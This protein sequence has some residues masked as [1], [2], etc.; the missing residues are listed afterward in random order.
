MGIT[1]LN[2]GFWKSKSFLLKRYKAYQ[3]PTARQSSPN[4]SLGIERGKIEK[5]WCNI[6]NMASGIS[7]GIPFLLRE[8]GDAWTTVRLKIRLAAG[9]QSSGVEKLTFAKDKGA[10]Y[11]NGWATS[12]QCQ[13]AQARVLKSVSH[14][15]KKDICVKN[16]FKFLKCIP[17]VMIMIKHKKRSAISINASWRNNGLFINGLFIK[18]F[19]IIRN[20]RF[21]R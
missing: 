4:S 20:L 12:Q 5:S 16:V 18:C 3:V 2:Y 11:T 1:R 19:E 15:R 6:E 9:W 7:I 10:A 14:P 13:G 8:R 17:S 21:L